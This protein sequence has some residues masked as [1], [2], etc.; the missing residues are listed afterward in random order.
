MAL[1]DYGVEDVV[2]VF[3]DTKTYSRETHLRAMQ[4]NERYYKNWINW[5]KKT[6]FHYTISTD[7]TENYDYYS[8]FYD[9]SLGPHLPDLQ[10]RLFKILQSEKMYEQANRMAFGLVSKLRKWDTI[11]DL[12]ANVVQE[13]DDDFLSESMNPNS[14]E[15]PYF[16][17]LIR[18]YTPN[19]ANPYFVY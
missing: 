4:A 10:F 13:A 6:G 5:L 14:Q 3:S 15:Y 12:V 11:D 9:N 18:T 7:K 17:H 19:T 1:T 8:V 2:F 16:Q